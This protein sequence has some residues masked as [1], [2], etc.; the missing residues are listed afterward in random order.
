MSTPAIV[1]IAA[2][3][4][5]MAIVSSLGLLSLLITAILVL[6]TGAP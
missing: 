4:H 6:R 3:T 5:P 2:S 1:H